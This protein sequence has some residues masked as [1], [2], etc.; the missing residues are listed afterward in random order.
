MNDL[1]NPG[2]HPLLGLASV[3][4]CGISGMIA[5]ILNN[6]EIAIRIVAAFVTI[7]TGIFALRHY[8]YQIVIAKHKIK[9]IKASKSKSTNP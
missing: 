2:H 7:G 9:N 5:S 8:Y 3:I 1:Q 4:I 6:L